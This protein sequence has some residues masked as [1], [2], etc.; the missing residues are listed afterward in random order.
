[1]LP[2]DPRER[3]G[4]NIE[5]IISFL[6][7]T[8]RAISTPTSWYDD[9]EKPRKLEQS[10]GFSLP[11]PKGETPDVPP[12]PPHETTTLRSARSLPAL[13]ISL[14]SPGTPAASRAVPFANETPFFRSPPRS[15]KYHAD[16]QVRDFFV[17]GILH[18][19]TSWT[20]RVEESRLNEGF[21]FIGVCDSTGECAWGLH[22]KSG[23]LY[24][25]SRDLDTGQITFD[26]PPP[27]GYPDG[28]KSRVMINAKGKPTNL[29]GRARGA[30]ITCKMEADARTGRGILLYSINGGPV[31]TGLGGFPL[32]AKMRRWALICDP[33]D[34][35]VIEPQESNY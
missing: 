35:I 8:K 2:G 17:G 30:L 33:R 5:D 14:P 3:L 4:P 21:F 28:C 13:A 11:P 26:A 31:L 12:D 7:P 9:L 25:L 29:R 1:M 22:P 24:R 19:D 6:P 34:K 16:R 15:I 32:K 20:V 23:L 18:I 27:A 10:T